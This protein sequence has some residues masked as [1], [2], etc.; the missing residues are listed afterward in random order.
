MSNAHMF[1]THAYAPAAAALTKV[2]V[3]T[4]LHPANAGLAKYKDPAEA[5]G[6]V[7]SVAQ[8][9]EIASGSLDALNDARAN[10]DPT[11]TEAG[12]V[13]A[14]ADA[15]DRMLKQAGTA[16][17]RARAA[18]QSEEAR[19][20]DEISRVCRLAETSH[21]PE[22][23]SVLRTMKPED[24]HAAILDAIREGDADTLAAALSGPAITSGLTT[25]QQ[26]NL[27]AMYQRKVAAKAM[28]DLEAVQTA[29]RRLVVGFDA[30]LEKQNA[31]TLAE[32]AADIRA[33]QAAARQQAEQASRWN[34]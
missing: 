11:L 17:D 19:L 30:L 31:L 12:A 33:K 28:T 4:A 18:I 29:G 27:R 22:I 20:S 24:R 9:F 7:R 3:G 26:N 6:S 25:E 5:P 21:S 16:Y 1:G 32:R 13:L 34:F 2:D 8:F 14:A 15:G 10:P 23:R